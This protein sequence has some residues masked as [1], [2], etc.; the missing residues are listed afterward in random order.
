MEAVGVIVNER[1]GLGVLDRVYGHHHL[2]HMRTAALAL[3]NGCWRQSLAEHWPDR[4]PVE[5]A[6]RKVLKRLMAD[7]VA[8]EPVSASKFPPNREIYRE[9]R[10]I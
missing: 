5:H 9:F 1:H 6:P 3:G 2:D 4:G 10:R 7:A 8:V